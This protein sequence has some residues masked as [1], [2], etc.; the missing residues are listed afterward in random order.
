M[1]FEG[2]VLESCSKSDW[3]QMQGQELVAH[4]TVMLSHSWV[5]FFV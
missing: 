4:N 1:Y 5:G 3:E 2:F